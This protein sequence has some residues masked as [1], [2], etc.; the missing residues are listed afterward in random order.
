[1]VVVLSMGVLDA[2]GLKVDSR[3]I[4][5]WNVA[6]NLG[7]SKHGKARLASVCSN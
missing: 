1:M 2:E 4:V 3:L 6:L 5:N 7:S